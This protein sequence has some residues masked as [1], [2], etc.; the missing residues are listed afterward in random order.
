MFFKSDVNDFE[1]K[2]ISGR[3][4]NIHFKGITFVKLTNETECH[5]GYKFR[6]GLNVDTI[7]FKPY[8]E[9]NPGGI[10]FIQESDVSKWINYRDIIGP[11]RHI[12]K[13]II[14]DDAQVYIEAAKFKADKLILGKREFIN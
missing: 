3:D 10:Y 6:D 7:V 12:R 4:F 14:P 9:C 5:N 1:G 13:V 2:L 8:G 11:M